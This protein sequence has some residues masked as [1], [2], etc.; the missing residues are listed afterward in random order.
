MSKII[1]NT[2]ATPVAIPD[3]EQTNPRM[4]DYIKNKPDFDGLKKKVDEVDNQ[5]SVLSQK[6]DNFDYQS[7]ITSIDDGFGNITLQALYIPLSSSDDN[8]GNVIITM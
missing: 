7:G 3:W 6:I 8:Q 1:G 4:V 5:L 2:T